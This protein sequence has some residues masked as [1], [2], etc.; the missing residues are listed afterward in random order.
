MHL[1]FLFYFMFF[2]FPLNLTEICFNSCCS[3]LSQWKS[4]AENMIYMEQPSDAQRVKNSVHQ[5]WEIY[6]YEKALQPSFRGKNH[7]LKRPGVTGIQAAS[8][9]YFAK[10]I[11]LF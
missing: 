8:Y 10:K 3:V 7:L 1:D 6:S 5:Q 11:T 4:L 9:T 2:L